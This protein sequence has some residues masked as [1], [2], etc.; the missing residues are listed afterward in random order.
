MKK[1]IYL[2][3]LLTLL[4]LI[5]VLSCDDANPVAPS[6]TV[7][8]VTANPSAISVN[9]SSTIVVTGFRPDGNP[10]HPGTQIL[11]STNLGTLQ[12]TTVET[13]NLGKAVAILTGDGRA[14][15]AT[16]TASTP[17]GGS[18]TPPP[19]SGGGTPPPPTGG[20]GGTSSGSITVKIGEDTST[21]PTLTLTA[22]PTSIS[23]NATSTITAVAR[24]ADASLYGA[25]GVVQFRSSLGT[26]NPSTVTTNANSQA[27]TTLTAGSLS[28]TATVTA[29]LGSSPEK[30]VDVTIQT[31]SLQIFANPTIVQT[32]GTSTIT[33]IARNGAG[34]PLGA[35]ERIR[36]IPELGTL[37]SGGEVFTDARGEAEDTFTAG[38]QAGTGGVTAI[39]G[40]SSPAE[41]SITIG[42]RQ[43]RLDLTASDTTVDEGQSITLTATVLDAL[44]APR[45]DITVQFSL[46]ENV[47][48]FSPNPVET[49]AGSGAAS[50]TL[51][52]NPALSVS[53]FRVTAT[54]V[55]QVDG[56]IVSGFVNITVN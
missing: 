20:G 11:L 12:P 24:N 31:I 25:G 48:T 53:S 6:G 29:S 9:G 17:R 47:G 51:T 35:G 46:S 43:T 50:T 45:G 55:D 54:S 2:L 27:I 37:E 4:P 39:L 15:S 26:L 7:L 5:S 22:N 42:R 32:G 14:G 30:T 40:T 13:D 34:L 41:V 56:Q 1:R 19:P 38:E 18:T 10:L 23:P 52:L 3:L 36:L 28:G 44:G 33:V 49:E 8:I 16:V 21:Q